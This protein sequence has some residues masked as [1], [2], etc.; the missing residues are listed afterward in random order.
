MLLIGCNKKNDVAK[1]EEA[2]KAVINAETQAWI[3]KDP[4]RM[5]NFISRMNTRP[6]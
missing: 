5:K 6:A 1:D 4:E 3:D 2:I